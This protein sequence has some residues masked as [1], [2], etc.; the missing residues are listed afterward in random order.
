M[1]YDTNLE[2]RIDRQASVMDMILEKRNMFGG[3]AYLANGNIAFAVR[4]DELLFRVAHRHA[5]DLQERPG[6]HAAVMGK[7]VMS[8][9]LQAGDQALATDEGLAEL[10]TIGYDHALNL[11]AKS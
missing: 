3:V 9:W 2:Q 7:R 1:A 6:I 11:S 8:N 4:R 5:D 10:M